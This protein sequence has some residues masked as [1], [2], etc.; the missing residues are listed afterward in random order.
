MSNFRTKLPKWTALSLGGN[1]GY[2]GQEGGVRAGRESSTESVT[3]DSEITREQKRSFSSAWKPVWYTSWH[4]GVLACATSVVVV[5]IINVGLTIYAATNPK[6]K[7]E[8]GIGTLYSGSCDKSRTIG[9]WLHL[10]INALSTVLLS[11][12]NYTQQCLAA[13]TR[14]EIDT[15]HSRIRWMDIGV[16]SIRNLFN[17]KAERTFLWIAIGITSIPLHLLYNSAVHTLLTANDFEIY[18]VTKDHFE[19][20]AY[21]NTSS[22]VFM[23]FGIDHAADRWTNADVQL[24]YSMLEGSN[25]GTERYEDL[26]PSECAKRYNT[27]F[28]STNRNLFLITSHTSN[29]TDNDTLL[30]YVYLYPGDVSP[31][32]WMCRDGPVGVSKIGDLCNTNEL[33]SNVTRGLPWQM[34]LGRV[35]LIS[36]VGV[37]EISGCKSER[38]EENCKVQFSLGIMIAVICCNLVKACAMVMTV[39]RSREPT[40]VTLGDAIDSFLRT[41]DQTTIGICYADRRFIEKEWG[42]RMRTGPREWNQKGAQRWWTSASKRRWITPMFF[43]SIAIV[44]TGA[45]LGMGIGQERTSVKT[46]IKSLWARGFGKLSSFSLVTIPFQNKTQAILLANLPQTILSFLY[47]TYNSL[48]TCMLLGHEWSLFSHHY[49]TLRVTSPR[50]GQRSTYWLQIPYTYAIPLMTLS[51]LLHWL[52]S[53]S[54]FLARVDIWDPFGT[55]VTRRISTVG[56]S[57]IAIIFALPLGV[58][59]LVTAIGMGY[60]PFA[61]EITAVGSCSA[62]I[63]AACHASEADL[64]GIVGKTVRW[65]DVEIVPNLGVRHL[66]FSSEEGVRKPEFGEVYAGTRREKG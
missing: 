3:L 64:E 4:T 36:S 14:R 26:E 35:G 43:C 12:S 44:I 24:F 8:G 54:I 9:L 18:I 60:R 50:P 2:R 56:Y 59:A 51:G 57:C 61:A 62:A 55:A 32:R 34:D 5:L 42:W 48:F 29:A 11:G 23:P 33:V 22:H 45:L 25:T 39:V 28:L 40:L 16:P 7:M 63:S 38:T 10:L 21:T 52:T 6:Y 47:L 49:R 20:G 19:P 46:D 66:A 53:Q 41:P 58:L 13:P 31:S 30:D 27:D 65:G 15:A 17:I 37:I 1:N